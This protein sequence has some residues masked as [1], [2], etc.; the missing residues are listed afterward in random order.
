[1]AFA[2]SVLF[3]YPRD[4]SLICPTD[5]SAMS[6]RH[7]ELAGLGADVEFG[8]REVRWVQR[9]RPKHCEGRE[10]SSEIPA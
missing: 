3:F 5:L 7:G 2:A 8:I 1:M 9:S 4:F 6:A 10:V